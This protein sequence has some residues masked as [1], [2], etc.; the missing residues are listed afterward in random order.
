[1]T[2]SGAK[3]RISLSSLDELDPGTLFGTLGNGRHRHLDVTLVGDGASKTPYFEYDGGEILNSGLTAV[4]GAIH[5]TSS[6]LRPVPSR[7]PICRGRFDCAKA[8]MP[9]GQ[10]DN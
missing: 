9:L 1:M 7:W 3:A 2:S 5:S 6:R 10:G 4:L 8:I